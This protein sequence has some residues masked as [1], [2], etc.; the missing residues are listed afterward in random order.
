M[1]P[2]TPDR[3]ARSAVVAQL[4]R[5]TAAFRLATLVYAAALILRHR[6]GY[7]HPLGGL[8]ALAA[9][10]GWTVLATAG[11]ARP[12]LRRR[13][14]VVADVLVA[15]ALILGTRWVDTGV[16]IDH[17]A[18]TL[19]VSWAAAPVLACAVTGG[20]WA[21][22]AGAAAVSAADV[23]ERAALAPNTFNGVVLLLITGVVGGYVVRL[24]TRAETAVERVARLEAATAERERIAREVH[25]SVL[26]V[27][28]LVSRRGRELGGEAAELGRLAGEGET[29]L[30]TLVATPPAAASGELELRALLEPYAAERVTV[31]G[32]AGP[33]PLPA[34][35]AE[36]VAAAVGAALDNVRRHAGAGAS[37]WVLV[38]DEGDVVTVSVRDDGAGFAADRLARAVEA[39]RLGVAQSIVGRM[40]DA[41]GTAQVTSSPGQ[42]TEVELR[43]T[44]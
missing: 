25:D 5:A 27:L 13:A 3:A 36:A 4:W 41:G 22:L 29:A 42:G 17:G 32:P 31:S 33:V 34:A 24:G 40:R 20:P 2:G 30:R 44:R 23:V 15:V 14:F 7:A 43:V 6:H 9:M 1:R 10:A 38:E 21:G 18:P 26:Q 35:A 8:L 37:A 12:R 39:G 19:P 16:H 11:Y 28:S